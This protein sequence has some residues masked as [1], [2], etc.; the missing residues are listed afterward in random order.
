M[1]RLLLG[2]TGGIAAYKAVE[3][4]R[5]AVRAGHSVRV[6]Q[7]PTS[8]RFVGRASFEAI[9][10]APVLVGEFEHDPARGS[11]PG[12]PL[13]EH[14]PISHLALVEHADVYLIAP[15]SA[16]TIAKLAHGHADNLVATAA[17]AAAC[18]VAVAPAM[19]V[20]MYL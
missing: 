1:A 8:E 5:L 11:Y 6:I 2:V 9:T 7:T 4:A 10:G 12:Q 17:L 20:R 3:T 13:P 15:A 19:N 18:P 14:A 16:D